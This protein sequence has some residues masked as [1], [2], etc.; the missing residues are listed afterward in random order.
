MVLW[1]VSL[2][3]SSSFSGDFFPSLV[4]MKCQPFIPSLFS[5]TR[6]SDPSCYCM[7]QGP[8]H[9]L[10]SPVHT[11]LLRR[12]EN[13][14]YGGLLVVTSVAPSSPGE[15]EKDIVLRGREVKK[16]EEKKRFIYTL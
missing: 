15:K 14:V 16:K 7:Q 4:R 10:S 13:A 12:E 9:R 8:W 1:L 3:L 11:L 6:A 2:S 5:V